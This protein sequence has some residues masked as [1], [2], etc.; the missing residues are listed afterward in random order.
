LP[1]VGSPLP[2]MSYGGSF[3]LS[4]LLNIGL[5]MNFSLNKKVQLTSSSKMI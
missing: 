3:L 4:N 2:F 1:V 5:V